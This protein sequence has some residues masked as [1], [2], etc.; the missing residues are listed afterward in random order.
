METIRPFR[1]TLL[2]DLETPVTAYLKLSE[3]APV[4]F[5]LESVE[6][7]RQSRFSIIGVGA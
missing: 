3:K 5:L 2:A 4:S 1:K 7:G 6:R